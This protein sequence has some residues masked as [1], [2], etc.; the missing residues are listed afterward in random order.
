MT[1]IQELVAKKVEWYK[2]NRAGGKGTMMTPMMMNEVEMQYIEMAQG[3]DGTITMMGNIREKYY[4]NM[5]DRYFQLVC[6]EMGWNW[7]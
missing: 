2:L 3:G 5:P 6:N 1:E 4:G 7:K